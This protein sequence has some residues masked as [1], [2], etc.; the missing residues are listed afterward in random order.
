MAK[1]KAVKNMT[2]AEKV[3]HL[4]GKWSFATL[5]RN[6]KKADFKPRQNTLNTLEAYFVEGL[7]QRDIVGLLS[8]S[9]QS[10]SNTLHRFMCKF[11]VL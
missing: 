3:A 7:N 1:K 6:L 9:R 11:E 8:L 10:V 5:K 4:K 2:R